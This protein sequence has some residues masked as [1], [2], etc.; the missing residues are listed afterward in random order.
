MRECPSG[1]STILRGKSPI[2]RCRPAGAM[3]QP[4]GSKVT[5]PPRAPGFS[6]NAPARWAIETLAADTATSAAVTRLK[7]NRER[8]AE[9]YHVGVKKTSKVVGVSL[10]LDHRHSRPADATVRPRTA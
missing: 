10:R 7:T 4:L 1:E 6:G 5:P 9:P 3:R 2:A 8:M